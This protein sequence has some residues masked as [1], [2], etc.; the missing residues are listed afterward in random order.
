MNHHKT[1][2]WRSRADARKSKL[3]K[4]ERTQLLQ[5]LSHHAPKATVLD[6][7]MPDRDQDDH[8]DPG[9]A[10]FGA[11]LAGLLHH[12]LEGTI[13]DGHLILN[14]MIKRGCG[15]PAQSRRRAAGGFKVVTWLDGGGRVDGGTGVE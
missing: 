14:H 9:L 11:L 10:R 15:Q 13:G 8:Q 6:L 3:S 2:D 4:L 1:S 7:R 12:D 5:A